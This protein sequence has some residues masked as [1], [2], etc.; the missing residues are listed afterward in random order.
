M[1]AT[2]EAADAHPSATQQ[3]DPSSLLSLQGDAENLPFATDTYDRYV[4]AGSIEYWPEPQRGITEAYR[5]IK[6]GGIACVIGPVHPTYP[7]SR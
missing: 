4:S 1:Q 5:V 6:P 7:L 3:I 2:N